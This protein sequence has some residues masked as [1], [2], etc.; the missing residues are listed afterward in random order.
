MK[1]VFYTNRTRLPWHLRDRQGDPPL[2]GETGFLPHR[3]RVGWPWKNR[4]HM[5]ILNVHRVVLFLNPAI[6]NMS[7]VEAIDKTTLRKVTG[8]R[9]NVEV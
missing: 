7:T 3:V 6:D 2:T 8:L 4:L 9:V 5:C 1:V